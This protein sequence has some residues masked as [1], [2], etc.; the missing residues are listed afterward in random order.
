MDILERIV[1]AKRGEVESEK[2]GLPLEA[3]RRLLQERPCRDFEAALREKRRAIIAEVKRRSPSKGTL[4]EDVDPVLRAV[5]YE[6]CGAAAVSVLTE[7]TFFG[8]GKRDLIAVKEN[9]GLPVLRKD[10]IIDPYQIYES[11]LIGAD[12][13]L[14]IAGLLGSEL[15]GFLRLAETMG[16][17][18]LV[19][20]H[21][22]EDLA[23][24][25]RAGARIVGINNRDLRTFHTDIRR[26]LDLAPLVPEGAVVVSE[27]GIRSKKEIR[28]LTDGGIHAFLVGE[29]FMRADDMDAKFREL[30]A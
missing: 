30:L 6:R 18:S 23:A 12:A 21:S 25:V 15:K 20:V 4:R 17:H 10:F 13:V 28:R 2:N 14:L 29:A 24:A 11:K 3:L 8:G 27:S 7:K 22:R 16:M 1:A 5:E 9:T 19:E 26:T